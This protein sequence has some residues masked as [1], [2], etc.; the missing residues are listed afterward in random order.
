[1]NFGKYAI[2]ENARHDL[3]EEPDLHVD[4]RP[5]TAVDEVAIQKF[6]GGGPVTAG[7][8]GV[9]RGNMKSSPEIAIEELALLIESSNIVDDDDKELISKDMPFEARKKVI[10]GFPS[11]LLWE[12]WRALGVRVPGWGMHIS[13][14]KVEA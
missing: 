1:M 3:E 13:D 12:L 4:F 7:P 14:P 8:A 9:T 5:P 6:L 11:P 2:L 10:Q